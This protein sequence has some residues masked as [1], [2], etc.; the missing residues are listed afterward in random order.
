[1]RISGT[2]EQND[3]LIFPLSGTKECQGTEETIQLKAKRST[4]LDSF[5]LDLAQKDQ[6]NSS[7]YRK[8]N[9]SKVFFDQ[10]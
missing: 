7:T 2:H 5:W 6:G 10:I 3:T 4:Y 1:M 9:L 8:S